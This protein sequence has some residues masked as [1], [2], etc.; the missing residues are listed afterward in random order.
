M[1]LPAPSFSLVAGE[2]PGDRIARIVRA[3]AGCVPCGPVA[4]QVRRVELAALVG[5]GVMD[6]SFVDVAT[7]CATFALGVLAAAGVAH[8]VLSEPTRPQMAFSDLVI[9]GNDL[10]AWRVPGPA[11]P[12]RGALM[13]YRL[14]NL[15]DDHVEVALDPPD[16]H[17]GGGRPLNA[18]T[19]GRG[20]D[21]H[22]SWS[23]PLWRWLDPE[24]LG[25]PLAVADVGPDTHRDHVDPDATIEP[26]G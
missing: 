8:R 16:E 23:R 7:N 3:Y 10:F 13:W 25:I 14:P 19:V 20:G 15:N 21:E 18:V 24:A 1:I 17:G 6:A 9:L 26:V 2:A 22:W 4:G 11:T 5:R 12:P